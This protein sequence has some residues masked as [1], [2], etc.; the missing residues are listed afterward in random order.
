MFKIL[1]WVAK[2]TEVDA[3]MELIEEVSKQLL[4]NGYQRKSEIWKYNGLHIVKPFCADLASKFTK[5]VTMTHT[6]V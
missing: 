4:Q 3:N 5:S 6:K 2:N 1:L